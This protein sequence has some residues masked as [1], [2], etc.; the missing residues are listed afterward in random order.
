MPSK[1]IRVTAE[2]WGAG[3]G[4]GGTSYIEFKLNGEVYEVF[5]G[6]T[7]LDG[8]E[9][10]G[11]VKLSDGWRGRVSF[12]VNE[13]PPCNEEKSPGDIDIRGAKGPESK[14]LAAAWSGEAGSQFVGLVLK[15]DD[16]EIEKLTEQTRDELALAIETVA[17]A[18]DEI[19]F[20]DADVLRG[21]RNMLQASCVEWDTLRSIW[22]AKDAAESAKLQLERETERRIREAAINPHK[23]EIEKIL[24]AWEAHEERNARPAGPG[25]VSA[26]KDALE[27]HVVREGRIPSGLFG[28]EFWYKTSTFGRHLKQ[29]VEVDLDM[30]KPD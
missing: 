16:G 10:L 1:T 22:D 12:V 23:N 27:N 6:G 29:V 17:Y 7:S 3:P 9:K 20:D 4:R 15:L 21:I 24:I 8:R 19:G 28:F 18:R 26:L 11:E 25:L 13:S 14:L 5:A 30:I 2:I